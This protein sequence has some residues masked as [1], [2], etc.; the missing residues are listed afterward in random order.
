MTLCGMTFEPI[1]ALQ[2]VQKMKDDEIEAKV[3][4][5]QERLRTLFDRRP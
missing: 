1:F 5:L 3:A 4:E 2:G